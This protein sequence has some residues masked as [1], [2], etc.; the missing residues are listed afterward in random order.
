MRIILSTRLSSEL[1]VLSSTLLQTKCKLSNF[2]RQNLSCLWKHNLVNSI[3]KGE[4][5]KLEVLS[6]IR[7]FRM[8]RLD[9]KKRATCY[10][11]S[12]KEYTA[13]KPRDWRDD[14]MPLNSKESRG[15]LLMIGRAAFPLQN[16]SI[17]SFFL[18]ICTYATNESTPSHLKFTTNATLKIILKSVPILATIPLIWY[19]VREISHW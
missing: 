17:F 16:E 15:P 1:P 8:R 6:R 2:S 3:L 13:L 18:S 5:S 12:M 9:K 10:L 14:V 19:F 11:L 7:S 4:I